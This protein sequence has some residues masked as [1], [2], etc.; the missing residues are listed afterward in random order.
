MSIDISVLNKLADKIYVITLERAT[1]RQ[2]NIK[3]ILKGVNYEFFYGV[4]KLCLNKEELERKNIYNETLAKKFHRN[5]KPMF[6]GQ[7][8][9]SFSHK[10]L[11]EK[12]LNSNDERVIIFED[13]FVIDEN[14]LIHIEQIFAELPKS[15]DFLYLGYYLNE[16]VTQKM[17]W[18]QRFY[19]LL[20]YIGIGKFS[21]KQVDNLYPKYFSKHLYKAGFHDT[22][23]AYLI[24]RKVLSKFIEAQTP[25]AFR[26]DTLFT[27]LILNNSIEAY[28]A[29]PKIFPQE[30]FVNKGIGKSYV[31][32]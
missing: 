21:P 22:S 25:I 1:E 2:E 10:N 3:Q 30:I 4:D 12:I 9:C 23:H 31:S 6:L 18:K 14:A 7:I 29:K 19:K 20:S 28:I 27:H 32:E 15:F 26:A 5:S 16:F 11:Y 24:H 17:L 8:A 13:D